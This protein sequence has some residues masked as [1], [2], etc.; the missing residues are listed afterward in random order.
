M[1]GTANY[2][3]GMMAHYSGA[4]QRVVVE[5][6]NPPRIFL[7]FPGTNRANFFATQGDT[8]NAWKSCQYQSLH[9][10]VDWTKVT[11]KQN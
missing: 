5:M 10:P 9:F 4:S 8:W 6:N 11:L 7:S 3:D 2:Q 1:Q